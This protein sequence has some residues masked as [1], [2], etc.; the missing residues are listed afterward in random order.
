[1]YRRYGAGR[2]AMLCTFNTFKARAAVREVARAHGMPPRE[3]SA[4]TRRLPHYHAGDIRTLARHLPECRPLRVDEDP[5]R[6]ILE[7]SE[8]IDGFP[9]HLS[10]HSGGLVIAPGPI[11]QFTPLQ[12]AA[13][14]IVITQ[15][16]MGPIEDLGLVKMD[17]LG[18]RSLT[19]IDETVQKVWDNRGIRVDVENL[20]DPD[21]LTAR[22]IRAGRTIGCF[23]IESPAMRALLQHTR[24]DNTDLLIK[25]LSLVRPGP[26]GSGMKK[27]FIACHA[28]RKAPSFLHPA[29]ED[30]LGGTYGVMLYQE[31]ILRVAHGIAGMTLAE[32][33]ALRRAMTKKRSPREMARHMQRFME[34][35]VAQGVDESAAEAIWER[36][37]NFA[38]YSY[39]K[40]HACTYGE[41]AYQC[42]YLK[43]HFPAEFLASVLTNRGGYYTAPVYL[44]EAKRLGMPILPPDVNRSRFGYSVEGEAIRIGFVE[45]RGLSMAAVEAI[46]RAR[47]ERPFLHLADL[48]RRTGIAQAD[49]EALINAG[50]CG[51][52]GLPRPALWWQM[53]AIL[54]PANKTGA[55]P[56]TP[57]DA[58]PL[59]PEQGAEA[60]PPR[61]PDYSR[62][63][64][65]DLEWSA[66][67]LMA[68][69]HPLEYYLA[70]LLERTLVLSRDLPRYAGQAVTLAG[71]LVA[72]RRVA[73]KDRGVMKFLTFED[74]AGVFE[75]VVFPEAYQ[76]YGHL[77]D[78]HGPFFVTGEVQ[79]E[80]NY[81]TLVTETI[82]CAPA[83]AR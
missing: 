10:I 38:K 34:R 40:A 59:F 51:G 12:R 72:E 15:Y 29:L 64:R 69:T 24:A 26:S 39:C 77:L 53:R 35:A 73:L 47:A 4:I 25:T 16:D 56:A 52:F 79:Y 5:L 31:D 1:V 3:V 21:P 75:A 18:H 55:G 7:V 32:A 78:S 83:V 45:V 23:Q 50:A 2:V 11:T 6:S 58:P 49:A 8:A 46:Q 62:R 22:L 42:T 48:I 14:G 76:R 33:D 65:L 37:A 80:D 57:P 44:E 67:G 27:E 20:P 66:L 82:E 13:K 54:H 60:L 63:K 30:L 71:W 68:S 43:A 28:G 41:I 81:P 70:L 61:L 36:I 9:R 17:L 74:P 19:V